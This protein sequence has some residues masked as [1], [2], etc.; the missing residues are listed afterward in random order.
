MYVCIGEHKCSK[1]K[2]FAEFTFSVVVDGITY[3]GT[4]RSKK[5]AKMA[6]AK[7]ALTGRFKILCV[8]SKLCMYFDLKM[9]Y[10]MEMN[11]YLRWSVTSKHL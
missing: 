9:R 1:E 8:P 5:E 3:K 6:A 7:S 10:Q 2:P 4:G 11:S